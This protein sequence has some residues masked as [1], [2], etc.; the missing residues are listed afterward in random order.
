[1]SEDPHS[2]PEC[3]LLFGVLAFRAELITIED[4]RKALEAAPCS[5]KDTLVRQGRLPA[6]MIRPLQLLAQAHLSCR[7]NVSWLDLLAEYPDLQGLLSSRLANSHTAQASR[8]PAEQDMSASTVAPSF[9]APSLPPSDLTQD[10]ETQSSAAPFVWQGGPCRY[11]RLGLHAKGGLGAVYQAR[12]EELGRLVALKE[13]QDRHADHPQTQARFVFEA[14]VTGNLEHPGIV[15]VYGLGCYPDGRPFYA[16]RFI[17][18]KSLDEEINRFHEADQPGRDP[19]ER[20]LALRGLLG[21]FVA[22]CNAVAY[23]HSRGVVHR[24]IKPGNVML[25]EFGET[26]VVDWGLAKHIDRRAGGVSPLSA[27]PASDA[28][29]SDSEL[30]Q[31]ATARRSPAATV[32]GTV[33]GTPAYM[34]PEQALGQHEQV[35]PC[36]DVYS[37]GATLYHLLTGRRPFSGGSVKDLLDRV[38]RGD[39]PPVRQVKPAVPAALEAICRKAMAI[40]P[41]QRY[42][43]ARALAEEVERWLADEPVLAH[44]EPLTDRMR[45]WGRRHRSL[46]SGGVALLLAGVLGLGLGLWAVAHEQAHTAAERDRAVRAEQEART[47]LEQAQANLARAQKA[48]EAA[49]TS[50]K[51]AEAN[52]KL[53]KKAVD[54]CFNV[55]R[56]HPL[57][58]EPRMEKARK[59][60]LEKTLPFYKN[61]R[62]QRPDDRALQ[63]EEADQWFRVGI[64]EQALVRKEARRAYEK[65][66]DLYGK[67]VVAYPGVD[68][69]QKDLASTHNNLGL[70]LHELGKYEDALNEFARARDLQA[71]L[72]EDHP[73]VLPYKRGLATAHQNLG[74][75]LDDL[76]KSEGALKEYNRALVI[77]VRLVCAAPDWPQYQDDLAR[78]HNHLAL[79]L[80]SLGK[81][82]EA[83]K[84][85][86]RAR[87]LRDKLVKAYPTVTGFRKELATTHNNLGLVLKR[88]GKREEALLEYRQ[89]RD[90]L[91]SLARVNPD[92]PAY[93]HD[94]TRAQANLAN[95]LKDLGKREQALQEGRQACALQDE[96][97]KAHPDVPGY[98]NDLAR[99]HNSLGGLLADLGQGGEALKEFQQ[100]RE[101]HARLARAQ[102]DVP[103]YQQDLA[104]TYHNLASL[105]QTLGKHEE[106]LRQFRQARDIRAKLV[107]AHPDLPEYQQELAATRQRLGLLLRLLGRHQQALKEFSQERGL[108]ARLAKADPE[109][110]SYQS[111]LATT[112]YN[113]G[114]LLNDMQQPRQARKELQ[115]AL[116]LRTNLV[117]AQ[118]DSADYQTDLAATHYG[119]GQV[120]GALARPREALREYGKAREIQTRL[121][122]THASVPANREALARTCLSRGV[123]LM[124]LDQLSASL[125][126]LNEALVQTEELRRLLPRN[127]EAPGFVFFGLVSRASVLTRLGE[128]RDADI[129][130]SRAMR[131]APVSQRPV[132]RVRR[133]YSRARA[134]DYRRAAAE[135]GDLARSPLPGAALYVLASIQALDAASVSRDQS[136]P[137]PER[138]K[139]AD[140][141]ARQ[142]LAL[143]EG[144]RRG[145][146]FKDPGKTAHL[147]GDN[148]LA[149]LRSRDDFRLW[150]KRLEGRAGRP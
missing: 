18:G 31:V 49:K 109:L 21:R 72:V 82:E 80:L 41:G 120:L 131:L 30:S 36:S 92:V 116:D 68:Q 150:L 14:E 79:V 98:R 50:L 23:A 15:P 118:P 147:K 51:R 1:M 123:L 71:R 115:Q 64:I 75:L 94:L 124:Q 122:Q 84:E 77:Q 78:T 61:F 91:A 128:Q 13:I 133:A 66:R 16:M 65:A 12:D 4:L 132:V 38:A 53:A 48:E 56:E 34:P 85:H 97:V 17:H 102:P 87:D 86:Q 54:E 8:A 108:R 88:L 22:V 144:A 95:M 24:D 89:A 44:R 145:G 6:G 46:V 69:Y 63:W 74:L 140:L 47:N 81:T 111:S 58:Q 83:L 136:R 101:I 121:V 117:K 104:G 141:W 143:L 35:G 37:L 20:A 114:A 138:E 28:G 93:R 139:Q 67:L 27:S 52:L 149:F 59:L 148:D 55:A 127:P 107:E 126:D 60:L 25:G 142:A 129:D 42:E 106:A 9:T 57:F 62:S 76:G 73:R 130:W 96:L 110:L 135:A 103:T 137:L 43:S 11:R 70:L 112:C 119:L 90:Q 105:L 19:G 45:R 99:M 39:C 32:A 33:V 26:L 2:S 146:Y 125:A 5:S 40:E 100:A 134:G 29:A 113:L 10:P 7:P 3:D